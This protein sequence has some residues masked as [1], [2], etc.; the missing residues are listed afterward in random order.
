MNEEAR[1][2]VMAGEVKIKQLTQATLKD[3]KASLKERSAEVD[4]LKEMVKSSNIQVKSKDMDI[5]RLNKKMERMGNRGTSA[6]RDSSSRNSRV[7]GHS[8][9]PISHVNPVEII[10]EQD[11]MFEQT[12]HD[13]YARPPKMNK[14]RQQEWEE[15][16]ELDRMLE[17]ER[18]DSSVKRI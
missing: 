18:R 16:V 7:S 4:V 11:E 5:Q 14:N 2:K 15:A 1:K 13:P 17:A 3:L 8:P 12:G 6:P 10:S 9:K